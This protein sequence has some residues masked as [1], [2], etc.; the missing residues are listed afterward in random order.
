L[1]CV[2]D[3][4]AKRRK[5]PVFGTL[6]PSGGRH[7]QFND[8]FLLCT[9]LSSEMLDARL[10]VVCYY[11]WP[12]LRSQVPTTNKK[13]VGKLAAALVVVVVV[14]AAV[15]VRAPGVGGWGGVA[16]RAGYGPLLHCAALAAQG[17]RLFSTQGQRRYK[18]GGERKGREEG[19]G[20]RGEKEEG[21]ESRPD[22]K[23]SEG[24][25][26]PNCSK[27]RVF[28]TQ[29]RTRGTPVALRGQSLAPRVV[30]VWPRLLCGLVCAGRVVEL[31]P[32]RATRPKTGCRCRPT[33][34]LSFH[35][36]KQPCHAALSLLKGAREPQS[37]TPDVLFLGRGR[38][39]LP[40]PTP[41]PPLA[42]PDQA[43]S[44]RLSPSR[45]TA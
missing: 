19:G 34:G 20:G 21:E 5:N 38:A 8:C 11:L 30:R 4:D 12:G 39:P 3:S 7:W 28:N 23:I 31:P 6:A 36:Y 26:S 15:A 14:V 45:S 16:H 22:L 41:G 27:P 10:F 9:L 24:S 13:S 37:T 43:R 29:A 33:R 18:K 40:P 1:W 2:V 32:R 35:L 42:G 17:Q 44:L 25:R